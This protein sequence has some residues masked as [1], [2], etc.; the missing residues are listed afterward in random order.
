M[1]KTIISLLL[2]T[3]T[4][5]ICSGQKSYIGHYT[6]S[7][8]IKSRILIDS[9]THTRYI[10]DTSNIYITA[11]NASGKQLWRTDPWKDN[12]LDPYRV[13]RPKIV[14]FEIGKYSNNRKMIFISYNNTQSGYLEEE[15]GKFIFRGQD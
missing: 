13:K 6:L 15:S 14:L 4:I 5:N 1:I 3:C 9:S 12:H 10:L 11:N 7:S 2:L 8:N